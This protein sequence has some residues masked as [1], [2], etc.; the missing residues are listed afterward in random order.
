MGRSRQRKG[1][2]R[3]GLYLRGE[4][5]DL[6]DFLYILDEPI[7]KLTNEI[8]RI[9]LESGIPIIPGLIRELFEDTAEEIFDVKFLK[10][11]VRKFSKWTKRAWKKIK[12]EFS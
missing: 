3:T 6:D 8:E 12:K 10:S 9:G 2:N 1:H 4:A 7:T 5:M 11:K